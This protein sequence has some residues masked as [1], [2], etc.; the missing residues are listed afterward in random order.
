M[1]IYIKLG[2]GPG[3]VMHLCNKHKLPDIGE[4]VFVKEVNRPEYPRQ[5]ALI[6]G[7]RDTVNGTL[8][9]AERM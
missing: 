9:L 3:K 6:D 8:Y 5:G 2:T 4:K 1:N 7:M